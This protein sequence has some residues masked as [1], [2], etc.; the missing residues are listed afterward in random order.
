[1]IE[2]L[3]LNRF[4]NHLKR[5]VEFDPH[6]T[7]LVGPSDVGKSAVLRA[8]RWVCLN[9]AGGA[10]DANIKFGEPGCSVRLAV[11]GRT[12]RRVRSKAGENAYYLDGAVFR[13]FGN[14]V[15]DVIQ[16]LLGVGATNFQEQHDPHFWLSETPGQVSRELNQIVDLGVI[17]DTLSAAAS[18]LRRA[19]SEVEVSEARLLQAQQKKQA[20]AWVVEVDQELACLEAKQATLRIKRD[21]AAALR[22]LIAK[23]ND[24]KRTLEQAGRAV[25]FGREMAQ[26]GAK[27]VELTVK[28]DRLR[29][30][31]DK[32]DQQDHVVHHSRIELGKVQQELADFE[33][34]PLC[35]GPFPSPATF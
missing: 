10:A 2:K 31:L 1:M 23:A 6:V 20:L 9:D 25:R 8:L 22:H 28:R 17:D 12:I 29:D 16:N 33:R 24:A 21:R 18:E 34:C 5:V 19:R 4:Q 32:A 7:T 27:L 11:D 26:K 35:N 30:L 14:S 3:V 15:P 13:A